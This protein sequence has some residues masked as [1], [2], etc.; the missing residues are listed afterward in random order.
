MGFLFV[1]VLPLEWVVRARRM[2]PLVVRIFLANHFNAFSVEFVPV[3]SRE[4]RA[5]RS[6][7]ACEYL[8]E[9]FAV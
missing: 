5:I 9:E 6:E 8:F 3:V 7:L 1:E 2:L 4:S